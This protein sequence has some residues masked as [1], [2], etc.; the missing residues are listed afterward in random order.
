M[1]RSAPPIGECGAKPVLTPLEKLAVTIAAQTAA[2]VQDSQ[3][4]LFANLGT[5][6]NS[7]ALPPKLLQAVQQVLAQQTSL[8][9]DLSGQDIKAAFQNPGCSSRL[10]WRQVRSHPGRR[11][12]SQGGIGRAAA[13]AANGAPRYRRR[14][15]G[16]IAACGCPTRV[17]TLAPTVAQDIDLQEILLPQARLPVADDLGAGP[18][19]RPRR[20]LAAAQGRVVS[21]AALNLLQ[22]VV[23]ETA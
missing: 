8:D 2:T 14:S 1:R 23:Q 4:P 22:E 10:R 5:A 15:T 17:P 16:A 13:G 20:V 21:R 12:R 7:A 3:A 11:A 19:R 6:I 9:P 18:I